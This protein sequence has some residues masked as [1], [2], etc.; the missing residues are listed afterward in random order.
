MAANYLSCPPWNQKSTMENLGRVHPVQKKRNAR[1]RCKGRQR[2][3]YI[4]FLPR[5]F[6]KDNKLLNNIVNKKVILD[7]YVILVM[8]T[9][10]NI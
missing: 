10:H 6:L 4:C 9:N 2:G 5:L 8:T 3:A 7:I 1:F